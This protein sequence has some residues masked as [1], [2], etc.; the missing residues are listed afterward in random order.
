M[1]Q[2][3]VLLAGLALNLAQPAYPPDIDSVFGDGLVFEAPDGRHFTNH[4]QRAAD[5]ILPSGA[6]VANDAFTIRDGLAFERTVEPGVYQVQL[7]VTLD[8]ELDKRIAFARV[9]FRAGEP[10]RWET[11]SVAGA[12]PARASYDVTSGIGAFMDEQTAASANQDYDRYGNTLL[13]R[14]TEVVNRDEYWTS[15][16]VDPASGADAVAFTSGYGD[17][18][19]PS[20]WGLDAN[21]EVVCLVT[22]FGILADTTRIE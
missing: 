21:D 14:L 13:Q 3:A 12:D 7:T 20:Y 6:L 17:G 5:L 18:V 16:V 11:A 10:V 19:Y 4:Q 8:D 2:V 1:A 9:E 22:D 15:V